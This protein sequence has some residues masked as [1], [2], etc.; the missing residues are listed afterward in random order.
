[1]KTHQLVTLIVTI[2]FAS[3]FVGSV[4][5]QMSPSSLSCEQC[6]MAVDSIS[7]AHLRVLDSNC[8]LHYVDCLKC[9]FKMLPKYEELNITTT[10]DWY[11]PNYT[12]TIALKD[13]ANTTTVNPSNALFIDGNCMKNRVV[14]NQTGADVLFANNGTS[15]YLAAL[16]NVTIP[17]NATVMTIVQAAALFAFSPSSSP[18]PSPN[19]TPSTS[20]SPSRSPEPTEIPS[21]SPKPTATPTSA[22]PTFTPV[23][24]PE[25]TQL[26]AASPSPENSQSLSPKPTSS[27]TL[28][29]TIRPEPTSLATQTC[30]ACGMEV[31]ADAQAKYKITDENGTVHYA[32]CFMCALNLVNKYNQVDIITSCDWYGPNYSITVNSTN[33]GS[34]ITVTPSNAMFL[35]GGSCVINRVAYN[36]TA[37]DALKTNG[38]SDF[39]LLQQRYA[40][41]SNVEVKTV[42]NAAATYA[43]KASNHP[44][45]Q[46]PIVLIVVAV[47]GV[48]IVVGSFVAYRKIQH[49]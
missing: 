43:Q 6:G 5:G 1:M 27:P 18:S 7:Q 9:A 11:G 38:F 15:K 3:S 48:A 32:E 24:T 44:A 47:A 40:L 42:E 8:T 21:Q 49:N 25:T 16:Q 46:T 2:L 37:A 14:Y 20:P 34:Q 10:C 12:I 30:E 29:V 39:T 28:I 35:N 23:S 22:T 26:P 45:S 41:P 36:Q 33:F 4:L 31:N 13:N 17:S 19:L